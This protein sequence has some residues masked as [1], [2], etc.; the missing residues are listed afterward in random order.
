MPL[1][2]NYN[3][4]GLNQVVNP[5]IQPKG[6]FI[7]LINVDPYPFGAKTKRGGFSTYLG[8]PDGGT[9]N[10]LFNWTR[11]NGTQF[12]NYRSSGSTLYY[13]TQGTGA[14]TVCGNGTVPNGAIVRRAV[15]ADTLVVT[16][17]NGT[18]RHSTNGTSFTDT[19]G[20]PAGPDITEYQG[21]IWVPGSNLNYSNLGTPTDWVNDSSFVVVP[22]EGKI[23]SSFVVGDWL[24]S[25]KD[26]GLMYQQNGFEDFNDMSTKVGPTSVRSIVEKEGVKF[27]INRL[28]YFAF[29]GGKPELISNPIQP[30]VYNK[31]DTGIA[32]A[33]FDTAPS[34]QFKYDIHTAVGTLTDDLTRETISNA[35]HVYDFRLNEWRDYSIPNFFPTAYNTYK[36]VNGVEQFIFGD[37]FGQCYTFDGSPTDNG[38]PINSVMQMIY[39][40]GSPGQDKR[41]KK[42]WLFFNPGCRA[43][44]SI[45]AENTFHPNTKTWI[46]LGDAESGVV[47]F[48][49]PP[50]TRSKLIFIKITESSK[51]APFTYYGFSCDYEF[52]GMN[53]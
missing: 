4:L 33:V 19:V 41:W 1:V 18:T 29:G 51:D 43:Q 26:S 10:S 39:D 42:I 11:N 27:W 9:V 5:L 17:A 8:T 22:N 16:S 38:H 12:W 35:V 23:N 3:N 31:L 28:G 13:S 53:R 37:A 34:G 50:E 45:A 24:Y 7:Q 14:W 2:N 6:E 21:R 40:G 36:D 20:A 52:E 44:V 46:P 15:S 32:G 47:E 30:Q 48:I 49:F 25:T